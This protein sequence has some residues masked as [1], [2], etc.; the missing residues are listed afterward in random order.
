LAATLFAQTARQMNL[1]FGIVPYHHKGGSDDLVDETL[2]RAVRL[3][4]AK[5]GDTAILTSGQVV[6]FLEGT[7]TKMNVAIV[8]EL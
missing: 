5:P 8:P 3:G 1:C 2:R 4:L 6:G 7:T